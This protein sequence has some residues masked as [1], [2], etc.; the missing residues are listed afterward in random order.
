MLLSIDGAHE[1]MGVGVL[2][3]GEDDKPV[4]HIPLRAN[5]STIQ[6]SLCHCER[7]ERQSNPQHVIESGINAERGNLVPNVSLR[8]EGAAI[9]VDVHSGGTLGNDTCLIE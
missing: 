8:A 3:S 7:T 4:L 1:V 9:S 5:G 2:A 6:S